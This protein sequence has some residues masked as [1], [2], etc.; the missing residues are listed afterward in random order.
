MT[1]IQSLTFHRPVQL[2]VVIGLLL[3]WMG[4]SLGAPVPGSTVTYTLDA[5]F[6]QGTLLS[7]NHDAPNSNQL[8]LNT[9]S[10]P[11]PFVNIAA[12]ARG[13]IIRIDVNTG[14]ILGEYLTAPESMGKK[15][16]R[17]TV[18][19]FGNVWVANRDEA[20]LS[21]G[22]PRGSVTR[23]GLIIG[24]TRADADGTP[25]PIGQYLKPPFQYSTCVDR[26]SNGVIKTSRELSNILPWSNAG[27]ADADGGVS[28]A[29]DECIVNYSRVKGTNTRT[30]AVD[31]NNDLWVGGI[32][33]L[34]HEKLDG[35]TGL[36]VP[37]TDFNLGC[38][39]YGGLIDG[40]GVLWSSRYGSGLLRFDPAAPPGNC[41]G[42]G[43]GD[44]GLGIDPQT[45]EIWHTYLEGDR[46]CKIAPDGTLLSNPCYPHGNYY[47]QGVAV[48]GVGNVWVA[49]SLYSTTVGHLRTDGTFVGNIDLSPVGSG[50][51]GVAVDSNGK[52]W[53]ANYNTGNAMRIDPNAG[54]IGGGGFP[55]G[56]VDL[57]V[58]LGADAFPYNYSD[59]TGFVAIGSTSPQ[60][61]WTVTQ[62]SGTAGNQWGRIAWNTE[63]Q[64]SEPAGATIS[65]EARAADTEVGLSAQTFVPAANG[66]GFALTGRFIEVRAT[67]VANDAN[68][69]PILSDVTIETRACLD[70][71]P[72]ANC[73]TAEKSLLLLKQR[74]DTRDK[75][76]WRWVKGQ[77]TS[78]AEFAD[79]T[80]NAKYTLCL[81]AGSS[82]ALI[83]EA[84]VPPDGVKWVAIADKAYKYKDNSGAADGIRKV[85]LKGSDRDKAKAL[86]K[87]KG[88][89]L[90]DPSLGS[91]PLPVRAQLVKSDRDTICLEATYDGAD[92]LKNEADQFRA[93]AR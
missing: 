42:S 33:N 14:T 79:P 73:R 18:D 72:V 54:P 81:Y 32:G 11:F 69:S 12:S 60:G 34:Y 48:D 40:N 59:M 7:V 44:Y 4:S 85:L 24:G 93:K 8:Q 5:D 75:L 50:P 87:G 80:N 88:P 74:G 76:V 26:D 91:L 86:V 10:T 15:S 36:P 57:V 43:L 78:T 67:L 55:V 71:S 92:I 35:V 3:G 29:D 63:L 2:C 31:A 37:G 77:S 82:S 23:V 1:S 47:A 52:V 84:A 65:V 58:D 51:T 25:N 17:T 83:A 39:G 66:I 53:V 46:V 68:V 30:V 89:N 19:Q 16:S 64:G 9:P 28:T 20:G 38:G 22:E 61:T 21:G 45:G 6:D 27:D 56:A 70:G 49:S 13:T 90:P 41:L 62:D